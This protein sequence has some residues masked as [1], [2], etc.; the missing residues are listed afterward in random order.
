MCGG[1]G[2]LA[3]PGVAVLDGP[4]MCKGR[5][6]PAQGDPVGG[7]LLGDD[8]SHRGAVGG[9]KGDGVAPVAFHQGAAAERTDGAAIVDARFKA[10]EYHWVGAGAEEGV[11][12]LGGPDVKVPAAFHAGALP[13]DG[14]GVQRDVR[15]HDMLCGVA[16]Q[17]VGHD[18]DGGPHRGVHPGTMLAHTHGIY[19]GGHQ[20]VEPVAVCVAEGGNRLDGCGPLASGNGHVVGVS[21][22]CPVQVDALVGAAGAVDDGWRTGDIIVD[23]EAVDGGCV[24]AEGGQAV[25][26]G[27]PA[28]YQSPYTGE[29]V[30]GEVDV[31]PAPGAAEDGQRQLLDTAPGGGKGDARRLYRGSGVDQHHGHSVMPLAGAAAHIDVE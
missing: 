13:V 31:L 1:A 18:G 2:A 23:A 27:K 17:A 7:D 21:L 20:S 24:A 9:D 16:A 15:Y 6:I 26:L 11:G 29:A 10:V 8:A 3:E 14:G 28:E 30:D 22:S 5:C 12:A 4:P 25:G 19:R